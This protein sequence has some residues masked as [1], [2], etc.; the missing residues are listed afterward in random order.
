MPMRGGFLAELRELKEEIML[1]GSMVEKA[2]EDVLTAIENEDVAKFNEIIKNDKKVNSLEL[3][4]NEKATLLIAKQQPV[5]SDLRNIIVALKISSDLERVGDL[6]VDMAKAAQR[7]DRMS[8]FKDYQSDLMAMATKTSKMMREVLIAYQQGNVIEAQHI[9]NVD[10][11]VDEAY[12][13][14][15]KS[16]FTIKIDDKET[17]EQVTQMAFIARYIERIAD[18]CTNIAEWIIYEVNGERFDLN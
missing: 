15:V 11:E 1:L 16:I 2:F 10:D 14:F 7:M 13:Q 9:A 6:A 8:Y 4:I 18:Y 12:G 5:A 3:D 17:A